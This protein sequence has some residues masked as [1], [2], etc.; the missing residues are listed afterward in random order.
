MGE[1]GVRR[2]SKIKKLNS[3]GTLLVYLSPSNVL[4]NN[5]SYLPNLS[6]LN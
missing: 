2:N 4:A 5:S 1:E 6:L 3:T